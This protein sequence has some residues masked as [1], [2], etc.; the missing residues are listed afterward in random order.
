MLKGS[1]LPDFSRKLDR[2]KTKPA[3][4]GEFFIVRGGV[5]ITKEPAA[6]R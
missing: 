5:P 4:A 6:K 1:L 2:E 3:R